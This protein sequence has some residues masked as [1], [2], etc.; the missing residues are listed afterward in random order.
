MTHPPFSATVITGTRHHSMWADTCEA[1]DDRVE[2]YLTE[3]S[4]GAG[5]P[6]APT[7]EDYADLQHRLNLS[8]AS[9]PGE[10]TT[11]ACKSGR[12]RVILRRAA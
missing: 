2:A 6:G 10:T 4:T 12:A 3:S 11:V 7:Y 5:K 9:A 8:P 1:L